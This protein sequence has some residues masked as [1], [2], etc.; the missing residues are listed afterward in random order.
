MHHSTMPSSPIFHI[1]HVKLLLDY[2]IGSILYKNRVLCKGL[3]VL[4]GKNIEVDGIGDLY[5]KMN[6]SLVAYPMPG[7][8]ENSP[9]RLRYITLI[10]DSKTFRK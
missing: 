8:Y 3:V 6:S 2:L 5:R 1:G 4:E 10:E 9:E 7:N